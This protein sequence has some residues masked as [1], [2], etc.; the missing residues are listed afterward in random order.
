MD[1]K[2]KRCRNCLADLPVSFF[3]KD[4]E[5]A[6]DLDRYCK[7]C[8]CPCSKTCPCRWE[9]PPTARIA[10]ARSFPASL[11]TQK[12]Q[13]LC[14]PHIPANNGE[15]T[16]H[17][18]GLCDR[19]AEVKIQRAVGHAEI[20]TGHDAGGAS[21]EAYAEYAAKADVR[22]RVAWRKFVKA[23]KQATYGKDGLPALSYSDGSREVLCPRNCPGGH[24]GATV[25]DTEKATGG[26]LGEDQ[27][28]YYTLDDDTAAWQRWTRADLADEQ[29]LQR[30]EPYLDEYREYVPPIAPDQVTLRLWLGKLH[31]VGERLP[32]EKLNGRR[33]T[34]REAEAMAKIKEMDTALAFLDFVTRGGDPEMLTEREK[35]FWRSARARHA[36]PD[37]VAE[38]SR[39][40]R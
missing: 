17:G 35:T 23:N 40:F 8:A 16:D 9:G 31:E 36:G 6:D 3:W 28:D 21:C 30:L 4:S 29:A 1:E 38:G 5:N 34:K 19:R 11:G 33:P 24:G 39:P 18:D 22:L 10:V 37:D 32:R 15:G 13:P 25:V 26:S 14:P 27:S 2:T 20:T 7:R 12:I